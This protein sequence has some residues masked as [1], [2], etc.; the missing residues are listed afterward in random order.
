M[1]FNSS[2]VKKSLFGIFKKNDDPYSFIG[3]GNKLYTVDDF[4]VASKVCDI[5]DKTFIPSNDL[6]TYYVLARVYEVI[7]G[8]LSSSDM[9]LLKTTF[10]EIKKSLSYVKTDVLYQVKSLDPKSDIDMY[11]YT[12]VLYVRKLSNYGLADIVVPDKYKFDSQKK[13]G[14]K[15]SNQYVMSMLKELDHVAQLCLSS[16]WLLKKSVR[17]ARKK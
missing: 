2:E 14:K 7:P 1:S 12:I 6:Y 13:L 8:S 17:H 4:K 11:V 16:L 5:F 15:G 9:N 3:V 10:M